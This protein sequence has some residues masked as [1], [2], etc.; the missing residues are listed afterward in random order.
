MK[1]VEPTLLITQSPLCTKNHFESGVRLMPFD[2][3]R[4]LA[5]VK[6]IDYLQAIHLQPRVKQAVRMTSFIMLW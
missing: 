6:T 3:Q 5:Q 1:L 2:Y 4:Q